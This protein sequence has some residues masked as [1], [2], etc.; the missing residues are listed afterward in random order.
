MPTILVRTSPG[1]HQAFWVSKEVYQPES[2]E[3]LSRRIAYGVPQCDLTGWTAGHRVRFPGTNNYKYASPVPIEIANIN[4]REI[5]GEVFNIFPEVTIGRDA[6]LLDI[7]W[8]SA[9]PTVL[10]VGPQELIT[11]L[12]GRLPANIFTQYNHPARDRSAALWALTCELFKLGLDRDLVYHLASHSKNNKFDDRKYHSVV[13]LRKDILRAERSV[14]AKQRDMRAMILDVQAAK[15]KTAA[16]KKKDISK[17]V[18]NHMSEIGEFIHTTS[19]TL[20]YVRKD[21]GRPII[22]TSHSEWLNAF[23]NS[24]FGLNSTEQEQRYVIHE[25]IAHTR[26]L[27]LA[28]D[29]QLL[30]YYDAFTDKLLLH[31]GGRDVLHIGPQSVEIHPNGYGNATFAWGSK[32]DVFRP[33]GHLEHDWH[34]VLF[35]DSLNYTLG[36]SKDEALAVLRSWFL[37]LLFRN[38]PTT[39]PILAIFGQPGSGKTTIAHILYRLIYGK[40]KSLS[41]I[42]DSEAFDLAV[43]TQPFVAFDNVDSWE[44]WLPDRIALSSSITDV[45]R[46]KLYTDYDLIV[47]QRQALICIT[48][49]NPRF[50]R[51]D[52]T[53][54]LLLILLRRY[55]ENEFKDETKILDNISVQ[56]NAI[57]ASIV[58][59]VQRVLRTPRPASS[60]ATPFRILDFSYFGLWFARSHSLEMEQNFRLA[61]TKIAGGQRSY[62]LEEDQLLVSALRGYVS[63]MKDAPDF[64]TITAIWTGI[65]AC[66]SDPQLFQRTYKDAVRLGKKLMVM[67]ASLKELFTVEFKYDAGVGSRV[68]KI[69][70]KSSS[71]GAQ[72]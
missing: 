57:W 32:T 71:V 53:D 15:N 5:G 16:E 42:T 17:V 3:E 1:R 8:V 70:P 2:L 59:D 9:Q 56:R 58:R 67:Q 69:G 43:V 37:Y 68:W 30:S 34:E 13:D 4:L 44:R 21:S 52:V 24:T 51:E 65:N 61:I 20:W 35:A 29:L 7:D 40:N 11:G 49:H 60:E 36:L 72:L 18:I 46:R 55:P 54:R 41:G 63:K 26:G 6:S 64:K 28:Q 48:A 45:E 19:G 38:L 23:L 25:L 39:R 14:V 47:L 12:R 10:N 62:N 31:T 50:M 22:I 27:P 33:E 66:A